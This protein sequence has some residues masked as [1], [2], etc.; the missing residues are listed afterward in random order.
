MGAGLDCPR[1]ISSAAEELLLRKG[2]AC[3]PPPSWGLEAGS[4]TLNV[5]EIVIARR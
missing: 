4:M 3:L 5:A 1:F 2:R